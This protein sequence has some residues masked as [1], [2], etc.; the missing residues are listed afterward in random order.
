MGTPD[1]TIHVTDRQFAAVSKG[2]K[3]NEVRGSIEELETLC[4]RKID[5]AD[6]FANACKLAA[7]KGGIDASVLSTYVTAK[8]NDTLRKKQNQAEQLQILFDE[9]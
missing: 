9:I 8:V 2:I 6:D 5:A 4:R 3:L 7:L 1:L